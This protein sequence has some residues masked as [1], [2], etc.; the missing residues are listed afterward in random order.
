MIDSHQHFW[1]Y[2][3]SRDTWIDNSMQVLQRDFLPEDLEPL[4]K[5]NGVKGCVAVQADQSEEETMFL[6]DLATQNKF[7]NGVVGWVDLR[8]SNISE[9]WLFLKLTLCLRGYDI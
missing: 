4:V 8:A 5:S 2:N 9:R 3:P 7:I 6:L 1:K